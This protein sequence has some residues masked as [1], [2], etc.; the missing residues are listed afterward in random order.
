MPEFLQYFGTR[1]GSSV[2]VLAVMQAD[3]D[4]APLP[5][6]AFIAKLYGLSKSQIGNII[7]EGMALG[8]LAECGLRPTDR[9]R[10]DY[11]KWISIELGFYARHMP[12]S[13]AWS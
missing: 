13:K 3:M 5:S 7:A 4:K 1:E 8:Y 2:V 11:R 9:L 6:R 12:P 10:A